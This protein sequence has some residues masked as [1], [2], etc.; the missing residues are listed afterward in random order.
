MLKSTL[1]AFV[2][3]YFIDSIAL[4]VLF[5]CASFAW[6]YHIFK[7]RYDDNNTKEIVSQV[8][9]LVVGILLAEFFRYFQRRHGHIKERLFSFINQSN[10]L[11]L[12]TTVLVVVTLEQ[13][14][15][16]IQDAPYWFSDPFAIGIFRA[17]LWY[18]VI[19]LVLEI[20]IEA[21][22]K[23]QK[24]GTASFTFQS[25]RVVAMIVGLLLA[26]LDLFIFEHGWVPMLVLIG[27]FVASTFLTL[28]FNIL[29]LV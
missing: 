14:D 18:V 28:V 7:E 19:L 23:K 16:K 6:E 3:F 9:Q 5:Q 12:I 2:N 13:Y 11:S 26:I 8:V 27:F 4:N 17:I 22:E 15:N 1:V 10:I 21:I 29:L 25:P 20:Y 24:H